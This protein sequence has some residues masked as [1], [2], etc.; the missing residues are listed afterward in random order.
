MTRRGFFSC[1]PVCGFFPWIFEPFV[2]LVWSSVFVDINV[3]DSFSQQGQHWLTMRK[4]VYTVHSL[5]TIR[6]DACPL[7]RVNA[8]A[9]LACW[10]NACNHGVGQVSDVALFLLTG[11]V[12]CML[13]YPPRKWTLR[14]CASVVY[15]EFSV[16]P[17]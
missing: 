15:P 16:H 9:C 6:D 17:A 13:H 8:E 7:S 12:A 11:R 1:R 14:L 3:V 5:F 10:P 4:P 2:D